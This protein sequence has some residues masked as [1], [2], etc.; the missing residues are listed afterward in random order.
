[1]R[2]SNFLS[3]T[4]PVHDRTKVLFWVDVI[5]KPLLAPLVMLLMEENSYKV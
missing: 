1:M 3:S 5:L 2:P 4:Q